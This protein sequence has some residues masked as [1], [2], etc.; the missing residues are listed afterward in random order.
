M[1]KLE[2]G[3][4]IGDFVLGERIH[5]GAMGRIYAA[6]PLYGTGPGFPVVVKVPNM[7][8]GEGAV[9]MVGLETEIMILPALTGTHVPRHVAAGAFATSPYVAM[10]RVEGPLR[11]DIAPDVLESFLETASPEE[12]ETFVSEVQSGAFPAEEHTFHMNEGEEQK[13]PDALSAPTRGAVADGL[14]APSPEEGR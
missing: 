4:R 11:T 3:S 6:A 1:L 14:V 12:V 7:G 9:G 8:R 13:L 10:E 5:V 2:P